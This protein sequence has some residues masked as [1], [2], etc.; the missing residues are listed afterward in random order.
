MQQLISA[1]FIKEKIP[2]KKADALAI[3]V[4]EVIE[5]NYGRNAVAL[6]ATILINPSL[7][8]KKTKPKTKPKPPPEPT[9]KVVPTF[10]AIDKS[11]SQPPK[12]IVPSIKKPSKKIVK[13]VVKKNLR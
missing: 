12:T 7:K 8:K 4:L 1:I 3:K 5:K 2:K 6:G 9:W 13:N 11:I 10:H